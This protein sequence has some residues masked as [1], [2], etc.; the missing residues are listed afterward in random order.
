[1]PSE[2]TYA[3]EYA[4]ESS[5]GVYVGDCHVQVTGSAERNLRGHVLVVTKPDNT[6]LVHDI[7]GYRPV[8]WLTRAETVSVDR[9]EGVIT[10]VDGDQWLRIELKQPVLQRSFPGSRAGTPI[11]TCPGCRAPLVHAGNSVHCHGCGERYGLPS[12][13]TLLETPC[14]CGLPRMRVLR[15][16]PFEL[17][18][19]RSCQPLQEAVATRFDGTWACPDPGCHG[20]LRI[21]H[22]GGLLAACD[23]Y[24]ECDI[25]FRFPNGRLENTCGCGLPRFRSEDGTACLDKGCAD[26]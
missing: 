16:E 14:D 3:D 24:P 20:D 7:D 2:T 6:V 8:A 1:M 9:D 23:A 18:I 17:C 4:V 22:R 21:V 5:F 11:G 10:A 13:A 12:G 25:A 26:A 15:G 19:D